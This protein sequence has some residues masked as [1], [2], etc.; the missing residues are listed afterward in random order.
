MANQITKRGLYRQ[1]E[2]DPVTVDLSQL[3]WDSG[4]SYEA[5]AG[6]DLSPQTV[7]RIAYLE[8]RRPMSRTVECILKNLGFNVEWVGPDGRRFKRSTPEKAA[9]VLT[10]AADMQDRGHR[11]RPIIEPNLERS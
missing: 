9:E 1:I 6:N 3:I 4:K 10:R 5:I 8:T 2:P 7:S 11:W